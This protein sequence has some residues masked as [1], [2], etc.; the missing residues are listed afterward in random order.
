Y[1]Q[2]SQRSVTILNQYYQGLKSENEYRAFISAY[3]RVGNEMVQSINTLSRHVNDQAV[4]ST[5][6]SNA[7]NERVQTNTMLSILA[8]FEFS[9]IGAGFLFSMSVTPIQNLQR[10]MRA[11]AAGYLYGHAAFSGINVIA[12]LSKDLNQ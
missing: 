2:Y 9:L 4:E 3:G 7:Q 11:L 5:A 8:V 12:H 1:M 6:I 10:V